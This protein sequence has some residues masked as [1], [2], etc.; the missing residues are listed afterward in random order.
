M[1]Y[2]SNLADMYVMDLTRVNFVEKFPVIFAYSPDWIDF[3]LG[4]GEYNVDH[5][6]VH[7]GPPLD[8]LIF[9]PAPLISLC[10]LWLVE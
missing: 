2:I 10:F 6:S 3:K 8:W 1:Q 4:M 9:P 5:D 7:D